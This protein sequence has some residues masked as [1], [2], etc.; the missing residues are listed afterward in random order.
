MN[1]RILERPSEVK[2]KLEKDS[3][4]LKRNQKKYDKTILG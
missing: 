1:L 3:K 4:Y 2:K